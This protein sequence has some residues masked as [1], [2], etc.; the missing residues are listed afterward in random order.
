MH[1]WDGVGERGQPTGDR[2]QKRQE[3]EPTGCTRT[4]CGVCV[5]CHCALIMHV[6]CVR[7]CLM[8]AVFFR[9]IMPM[10][11]MSNTGYVDFSKSLLVP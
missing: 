7:V 2:Q 3:G 1:L 6:V 4:P 11:D 10:R 5:V 9:T 8:S